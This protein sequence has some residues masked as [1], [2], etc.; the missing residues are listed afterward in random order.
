MDLTRQMQD[1]N[2]TVYEVQSVN[3]KDI[4]NFG[5]KEIFF[6][7]FMDKYTS[8]VDPK[9]AEI[10]RLKTIIDE[11][12]NPTKSRKVRKRLLPEEWKEVKNLIRKGGNNTDIANM[13][14]ISDSAV[15]K[16][17][18]ELRQMGEKV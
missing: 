18:I 3:V 11:L 4:V 13:Y 15:S 2:G 14:D 7:E 1:A 12:R 16:K 8:Y 9:D 10:A 17:R 6:N 5:K